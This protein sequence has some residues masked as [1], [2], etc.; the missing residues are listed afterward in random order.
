MP[1]LWLQVMLQCL[2]EFAGWAH[3]HKGLQPTLD[4]VMSAPLVA[5]FVSYK[6]ARGNASSTLLR[7]ANQ[8][9]HTVPFVLSGDC[10]QT[11]TYTSSYSSQL[12][13]WYGSLK[14]HFREL[15]SEA[16]IASPPAAKS[17]ISLAEQWEHNQAEWERLIDCYQVRGE[18]K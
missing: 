2:D 18:S 1:P 10:I 17:A 12:K 3:K 4:L 16:S 9:S 7:A 5:E 13:E 6:Q 8:L 11:K 15:V 14:A